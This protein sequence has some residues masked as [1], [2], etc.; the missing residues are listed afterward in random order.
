MARAFRFIRRAAGYELRI[1]VSLLRWLIRRPMVPAGAEPAGYAGVVQPLL[2]AFIAVSV[3]ELVVLHLVLPWPGVRLIADLLGVWGVI[4]MLGL[5]GAFTRY[6]HLVA[7]QAL[8]IRRGFDLDLVVPWDAVARVVVRERG[9]DKARGL[10]VDQSDGATV[11]HVVMASRTNLDL[12]LRR[13]LVVRLPR[14]EVLVDEVRLFADEPGDLAGRIWS[15]IARGD[16]VP[17]G[18]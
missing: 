8:R 16:G 3:V 18:R 10:Q 13:P 14:G 15:R 4:W 1:Y 17:A 6:P 7:D 12:T 11:V 5:L 2:W 9:R